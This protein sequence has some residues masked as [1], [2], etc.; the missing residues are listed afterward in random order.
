[1]RALPVFGAALAAFS[2]MRTNGRRGE[3]L[4]AADR[5]LGGERN[6][7]P[8]RAAPAARRRCGT[9]RACCI[10]LGFQARPEEASFDKPAGLPC[11]HLGERGCGIYAGRPPVC[12]RFQCGWL[13]A[14]NL[15]EALRPDRCGVLVCANDDLHGEGQAIYAYE[16]A[17]G[18]ADAPLP[19][20]LIGELAAA[21]TVILVRGGG[22]EVLTADPAVQ[23]RLE[24]RGRGGEDTRG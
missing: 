1:M 15:P 23:A 20:W 2:G 17:P 16:L 5:G 3:D 22:C 6:R 14:P 18:A 8:R 19:A 10:T 12:R 21:A 4:M 24:A 11:P 9:C 7:S 13:Q